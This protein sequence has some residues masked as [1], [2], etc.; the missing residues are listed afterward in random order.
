MDAAY[1][2]ESFLAGVAKGEE[3]LRVLSGDEVSR[4]NARGD[5]S[6]LNN[7]DTAD[8]SG[9]DSRLKLLEVVVV[10]VVV[11][12]LL[13]LLLM[14]EDSRLKLLVLEPSL[15]EDSRLKLLLESLRRESVIINTAALEHSFSNFDINIV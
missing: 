10:V 6:R 15:G 9:D 14:G 13:L 4:L 2:K 8:A 5:D 1:V 12:L 11:V 7:G 3:A